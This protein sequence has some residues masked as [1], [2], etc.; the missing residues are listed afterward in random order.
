MAN[1]V[2]LSKE[3]I[4][5]ESTPLQFDVPDMDCDDCIQSITEALRD[6]D[7]KAEVL[8]DLT[9]KRVMIGAQMDAGRAAEAIEAAGFSPQ[10]AG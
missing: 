7:P 3:T 6:I 4:M 1:L 10:A 8:A 9:T 2:V 5:A